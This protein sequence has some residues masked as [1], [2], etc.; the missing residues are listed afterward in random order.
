VLRADVP[1]GDAPDAGWPTL[2]FAHG[3]GGGFRSAIDQGLA[4]R[5]GEAGIAT[6]SVDGPLHGE[7]RGD[8]DDD[9]LVGNLP[10]D[11]LVFNLRNP[12]SAR[13]T[14]IQAAIDLL[15]SDAPGPR[16]RRDLARGAADRLDPANLFFMGHSQGAQAGV[17]FLPREPEVRAAVLSGAGGNLIQALLDQVE[18]DVD[19]R[20]RLVPPARAA[21]SGLSGA[22]RP[23]ADRAHPVLNM[24]FNT[25]VNR[26]DADAYSPMLRRQALPEIG[27]KHILAYMGHTDHYTP[28]RSAGSFV[29][30]AGLEVGEQNLFPAPCDQYTDDRDN[31]CGYTTSGFLPVT[32][33]PA[34]GNQGGVTSVVLMREQSG[35]RDGHFVAFAPAEQDR[36]VAFFTSAK[37]GAVPVVN[38]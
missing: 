38:D 27:A 15:T 30:G 12:D 16:A 32:P 33:L 23:P 13:D 24:L 25:F 37:D 19:A 34:S 3:T 36:I 18:A 5:L 21:A 6:L 4:R 31:A 17:L 9:G 35:E 20:R 29:I 7:R 22:A 28:L 1:S 2:V 14:P 26:S 8:D 10:L 11:Q